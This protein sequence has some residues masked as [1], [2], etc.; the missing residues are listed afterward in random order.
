METNKRIAHWVISQ[1]YFESGVE[2]EETFMVKHC[3]ESA[4]NYMTDKAKEIRKAYWG[5]DTTIDEK[6]ESFSIFD[7]ESGDGII[8]KLIPIESQDW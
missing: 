1:T 6:R 3:F 2:V 7:K 5:L 4:S 8:L